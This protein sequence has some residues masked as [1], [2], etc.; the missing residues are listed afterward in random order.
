MRFSSRLSLFIT[1]LIAA[2]SL[3]SRADDRVIMTIDNVTV[4]VDEFRYMLDKTSANGATIVSVREFASQY[5]LFKMKVLEAEAA[6]LDTVPEF[7]NELEQY[8]ASIAMD[9]S[10]LRREYREGML[11][12]EISNR[13]IWNSPQLNS[14]NLQEHFMANRD[15]FIWDE[16]RAKGWLL[17]AEDEETMADARSYLASV[18]QNT[19]IR[20]ALRSRFG[21]KI[22]AQHILA[23]QGVNPVIDNIVFNKDTAYTL[24]ASWKVVSAYNCRIIPS[25]E[26]WT[27]VRSELTDDFQQKLARQWETELWSNHDVQINYDIID[28]AISI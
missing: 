14:E 1:V 24:N 20:M 13:N 6:G 25:P 8:C 28:E 16:P 5:A 19:D 3:S 9:D 12:Y 17:L 11:L 2:F 4:S 22:T 15:R 26:E 27:D 23:K 21:Y 10:N 18:P 7:C